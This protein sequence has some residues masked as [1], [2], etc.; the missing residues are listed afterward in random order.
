MKKIIMLL[1]SLVLAASWFMPVYA[2]GASLSVDA[3]SGEVRPGDTVTF[4]VTLSGASEAKSMALTPRYDGN[5]FEM[6]SGTWLLSGTALASFD[7]TNAA[8]AYSSETNMNGA[9]FQFKLRVRDSAS[10]GNSTVSVTPVIKNGTETI[11]ASGGSTS[12]KVSCSTHQ[13]GNYTPLDDENHQHV[14][15]TCGTLEVTAHTWNGGTVT[16]AA[17]CKEDGVMTYRCTLCG[18]E[19]TEIIGKTMDHVFGDW[20]TV[21]AATC[22]AD[23]ERKHTCSVCGETK[24]ETIAATAHKFGNWTVTKEATC[25]E[26]GV[27]TRACSVCG[28]KETRNTDALGHDFKEPVIVREATLSREGLIEGICSRCGKTTQQVIPCT[29]TDPETG[30]VFAA[31]EG[32]FS[33]G[34]EVAAK[35]IGEQN[36]AFSKLKDALDP[37][38]GKFTV[39]ELSASCGGSVVEPNGLVKVTFPILEGYT[40]MVVYAVLEDGTVKEIPCEVDTDGAKVWIKTDHFGYYA[41]CQRGRNEDSGKEEETKES[42]EASME[43]ETSGRE[44]IHPAIWVLIVLVVATAVAGVGFFLWRRKRH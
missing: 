34:T 6:V 40:D 39:Y 24:R 29:A 27:Q 33:D 14:C 32:V 25:T 44:G 5:V 2:S 35:K 17:S 13:F 8:A 37:V 7:G 18:A 38:S 22:T 12:V 4:T 28:K 3:S 26:D 1:V 10:M 21:R 36:E 41:V 15:A 23:G 42:I 31:E 9:V 30:I 43:K 16:K 19:K 20:E 11:A